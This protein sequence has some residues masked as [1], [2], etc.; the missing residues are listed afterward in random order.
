MGA[1]GAQVRGRG[2]GRHRGTRRRDAQPGGGRAPAGGR[3]EEEEVLPDT[4]RE[5]QAHQVREGR[6]VEEGRS[7]GVRVELPLRRRRVP[8]RR[9]GRV[10][11]GRRRRGPRGTARQRQR[12][13]GFGPRR[14]LRRGVRRGEGLPEPPVHRREFYFTLS[15]SRPLGPRGRASSR[16]FSAGR[17]VVCLYPL[18]SN[19]AILSFSSH[20]TRNGTSSP[21]TSPSSSRRRSTERR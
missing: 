2:E 15:C 3:R 16:G 13:A 1:V 10:V 12:R 14:P 7:R 11:R 8:R 21:S 19:T 18:L 17:R 5:R 9:A 4:P 20:R 6:K